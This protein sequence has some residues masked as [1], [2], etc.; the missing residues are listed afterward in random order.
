MKYNTMAIALMLYGMIEDLDK[1]DYQETKERDINELVD[2]L[3]YIGS[4]SNK[5]VN[6]EFVILMNILHELAMCVV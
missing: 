5:G 4:F 6:K 2:D 1:E 3:N